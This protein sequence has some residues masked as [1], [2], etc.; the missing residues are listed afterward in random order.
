MSRPLPSRYARRVSLLRASWPEATLPSFTH[1]F[2]ISCCRSST[3]SPVCLS[4]MVS[5]AL[6]LDRRVLESTE[7]VEMSFGKLE[8]GPSR[9]GDHRGGAQ[10]LPRIDLFL[11]AA[12]ALTGEADPPFERKLVGIAARL[13]RVAVHARDERAPLV[14]GREVRAPSVGEPPDPFERR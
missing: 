13:A 2:L 6:L 14:V 4:F 8:A 9:L 7:H 10:S 5:F 3:V 12:G 11:P 1:W